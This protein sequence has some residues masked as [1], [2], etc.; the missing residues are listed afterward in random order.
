MRAK[1]FSSFR[2][3]FWLIFKKIQSIAFH[4]PHAPTRPSAHC[5][6]HKVIKIDCLIACSRG[7]HL[8]SFSHREK[9]TGQIPALQTAV[10]EEEEGA[11]GERGLWWSRAEGEC[12]YWGSVQWTRIWWWGVQSKSEVSD[13]DYIDSFVITHIINF[14]FTYV[15]TPIVLHSETT[16]PLIRCLHK[17]KVWKQILIKASSCGYSIC[18]R[19][20]WGSVHCSLWRGRTLIWDFH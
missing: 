16:R 4:Y 7:Y 12:F 17:M 10:R 15:L 13:M 20:G 2:I 1:V 3:L 18:R 6:L 9:T 5:P 19:T 14:D 11:E 8:F